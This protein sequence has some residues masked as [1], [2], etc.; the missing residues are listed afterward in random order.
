MLLSLPVDLQPLVI[1]QLKTRDL[2]ALLSTC[3]AWACAEDTLWRALAARRKLLLPETCTR[4]TRSHDDRRRTLLKALRRRHESRAQTLAD[5]YPTIWG[6]DHAAKLKAAFEADDELDPS[7]PLPNYSGATLLHIA[8][9]KGRLRCLKELLEMRGAALN[10]VDHNNFTPL[11][12]AAWAGNVAAVEYLVSRGAAR[13]IAGVPPMTSLCGGTGPYTPLVWA[14]RKRAAHE[15]YRRE[16]ESP[17]SVGA[18]PQE[19]AFGRIVR[20]LAETTCLS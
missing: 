6:G 4:P 20:I 1:C 15:R 17:A 2:V 11:A 3:G 16:H 5:L 19:L 13:G 18:G 8:A 14:E 10:A 12:G 9:R 7:S